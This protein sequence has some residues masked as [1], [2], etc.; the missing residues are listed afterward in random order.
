MKQQVGHQ[1]VT[2]GDE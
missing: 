1:R 2:V